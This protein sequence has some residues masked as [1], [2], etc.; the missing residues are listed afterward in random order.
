MYYCC[1]SI[2]TFNEYKQFKYEF[3]LD[4]R[5]HVKRR[6][7]EGTYLWNAVERER[8]WAETY[9]RRAELTGCDV[10]PERILC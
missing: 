9:G 7:E 4:G 2:Q 1:S 10:R 5:Q 8:K 6:Q 3:S